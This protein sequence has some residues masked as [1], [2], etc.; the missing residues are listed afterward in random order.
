ML[1]IMQ[2]DSAGNPLNVAMNINVDSNAPNLAGPFEYPAN[3][4]NN[5]LWNDCKNCVT[6]P[7]T[8]LREITRKK[9]NFDIQK[10]TIVFIE[11]N[12]HSLSS[13]SRWQ[14]NMRSLWLA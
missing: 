4:K 8:L 3:M 14:R 9:N 1:E 5:M 12:Y 6:C 10:A 11:N 2:I 7:V 13:I